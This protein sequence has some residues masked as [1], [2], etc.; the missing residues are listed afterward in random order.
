MAIILEFSLPAR[1]FALEDVLEGVPG[2]ELELDRVVPTGERPLPF[3]WV[4]SDD[5]DAFEELTREEPAVETLELVEVV[6]DK[7]LY[8]LRWGEQVET[9]TMGITEAQGTI[10]DA[11]T[12]K[13]S[14]EFTLRF[15]DRQHAK[16]FQ[17][18]CVETETPLDLSKVYELSESGAQKKYGLTEKQYT[19]LRLAYE[20][21]YFREPRGADL[22]DLGGE[23]DISPR[24]VSYR[25]RRGVSSLVEHSIGP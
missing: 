15:P 16:T 8:E 23:L 9:L 6:G 13:G 21:G 24:A 2:T 1:A 11:Q 3:L 10:V 14:W 4:E 25:L 18:Y 7:R 17:G 20:R 5:F 19:A 12:S 22:A